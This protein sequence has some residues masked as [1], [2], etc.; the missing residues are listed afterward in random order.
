MPK[1]AE[2]DTSLL[3]RSELVE[4]KRLT[5][6]ATSYA[7]MAPGAVRGLRSARLVYVIVWN[8]GIVVAATVGGAMYGITFS[9]G[10]TMC[11]AFMLGCLL[12]IAFTFQSAFA[13]DRVKK[14]ALHAVDEYLESIG[15][16]SRRE[17]TRDSDHDDFQFK[18]RRQ[19]QHEWYGDHSELN[20][21]HREQ[22]KIFGMDADTYV[23]NF[24][25]NDKD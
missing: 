25:E 11:T 14:D 7:T 17:R 20:W 6:I 19:M 8:I 22:A 21:Q 5:N 10:A 16:A 24:L 23:S 3:H 12:S 13:A 15:Y 9:I 4:Y 1:R 18:S 2:I